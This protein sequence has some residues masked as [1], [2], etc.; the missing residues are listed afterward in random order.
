ML[1]CPMWT[2]KRRGLS[3]LPGQPVVSAS[4]SP[5]DKHFT[6]MHRF[7]CLSRQMGNA[8]V[9]ALPLGRS[10]SAGATRTWACQRRG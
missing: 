8:T 3:S 7:S 6:G 1:Q 4:V 10:E 9:V 5:S 2:L